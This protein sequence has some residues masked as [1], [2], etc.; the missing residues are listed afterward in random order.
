MK[1]IGVIADDFTGATDIACAYASRGYATVVVTDSSAVAG[2]DP[3]VDVIV[4]ALKSRTAPIG[5][6]VNDSRQALI[7]LRDHGCEQF[8]FKYCSTFDSTEQGNI[9]PVLDALSEE[10]GVGKVVVVPSF[11]DNGRTV[12]MGHLFVGA[13]LLDH[14]SMR[15]HPLTPMTKSRIRDILGP[16]TARTVS[17]VHLPVVRQ[18]SESLSAAIREAP[19]TYVVVDA[20]DNDDLLRIGAATADARLVSGASGIAIGAVRGPGGSSQPVRLQPGGRLVV[21]GSASA[22]TRAQINHAVSAGAPALHLDAALATHS[23]GAAASQALAWLRSHSSTSGRELAPVI[24]V[25]AKDDD[26]VP[27]ADPAKVEQTLAEIVHVAV[28]ELGTRNLIVAGGESSGAVVDRLGITQ[29]TIG[30]TIAA[31]VC[32]AS[33]RTS[34]GI[35]MNVALKSGNFG[36]TRM[37]TDAWEELA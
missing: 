32:W 5:T 37:F 6:A 1:R 19:G 35:T 34:E 24:F 9:G 15:H 17:E 27:D 20:L 3:Q 25:V 10:L 14:S 28:T 22:T 30:P 31:G 4:V 2:V 18:G 33:A 12:Y 21:C 7:T 26:F 16:Q 11:P 36:G 8:V 29:L 13:D 23:P